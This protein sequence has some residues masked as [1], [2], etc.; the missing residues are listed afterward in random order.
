LIRRGLDQDERDGL[1]A[2]IGKL[3]GGA[4]GCANT[5]QRLTINH[6]GSVI[7]G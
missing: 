7:H 4:T 3:I 6:D 5:R 1:N 2:V